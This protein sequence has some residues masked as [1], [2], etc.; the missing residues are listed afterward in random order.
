MAPR[1][2]WRS[3]CA[4]T[5]RRSRPHSC[6]EKRSIPP[7]IRRALRTRDAGCRFPGCTHERYVDAHHIEHWADGGETKLSNL[8]TLCRLHH[9]L[10]HEGQIRIE[11]PPEG[12]WRFVRPDGRHYELIRRTPP[13][14]YTGKELATT[15]AELGIHIDRYTAGT[16]WRGERMDYE[17]GVWVLCQQAARARR[18]RDGVSS[19]PNVSAETSDTVADTRS[20]TDAD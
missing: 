8:V 17:L 13:A 6:P 16:R 1:I 14:A 15:H 5:V 4:G 10:V 18:I 19:A 20:T 11:T 3:W 2:T 12:G 9:R 7:A